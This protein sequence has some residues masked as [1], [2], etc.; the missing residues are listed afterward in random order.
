MA[1]FNMLSTYNINEILK[2][3]FPSGPKQFLLEFVGR[4]I[5]FQ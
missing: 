3:A 1:K 2:V 5:Q 4:V